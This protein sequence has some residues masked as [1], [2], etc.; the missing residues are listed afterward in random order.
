M[1][2]YEKICRYRK[3][4]IKAIIKSIVEYDNPQQ[5]KQERVVGKSTGIIIKRIEN[6]ARLYKE[7]N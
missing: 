2:L 1:L 7:K 4:W 6:D 5:I 3:K